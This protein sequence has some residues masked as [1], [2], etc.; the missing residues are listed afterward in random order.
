MAL[1]VHGVLAI[2][3]GGCAGY[4]VGHHSL[5][6]SHIR[7]VYVPVFAN[8]SFRRNLG[9]QLTEAVIKEIEKNSNY[10]VVGTPNADSTLTGKIVG[11]TKRIVVQ[12]LNSDPR[13]VQVNLQVQVNWI[14]NRRGAVICEE[15]V[16]MTDVGASANVIPEVGQSIAT[17]HQQAMHRIAQQIVGL[18]EI[19]W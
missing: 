11:E 12:N 19:P 15:T 6:P 1:L 10:K 8:Q 2:G 5:F 3:L 14:D 16:E 13:E 4:Q 9:E 18:M 17:G 7:T